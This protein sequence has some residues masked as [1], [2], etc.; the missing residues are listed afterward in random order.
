MTISALWPFFTVPWVGL[1]C[2]IVVFPNHTH[3][4][5]GSVGFNVVSPNEVCLI[6]SIVWT[7]NTVW[8]RDN[9]FILKYIF[10]SRG[11]IFGNC[12]IGRKVWT[13]IAKC[14]LN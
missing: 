12:H 14:H 7:I 4:L 6:S 13:E 10:A 1:Q 2:E 11:K 5:L 8:L 9:I 3:L